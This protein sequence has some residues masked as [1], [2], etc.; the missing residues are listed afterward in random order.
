MGRASEDGDSVVEA[1]SIERI[2]THDLTFAARLKDCPR[3]TAAHGIDPD[4]VYS[5][6]LSRDLIDPLDFNL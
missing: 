4:D 3:H 2:H 1:L 6:K 5:G